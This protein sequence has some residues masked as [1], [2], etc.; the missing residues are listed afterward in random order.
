MR[1]ALKALAFRAT[2]AGAAL[3]L[4]ALRLGD[5]PAWR[6]PS[7]VAQVPKASEME[8]FDAA[9]ELGTVEAWDAFLSNYPTG[10]HAD[11]ARAYVK[12]LAEPSAAPAAAVPQPAPPVTVSATRALEVGCAEQSR[13][14]SENSNER[15]KIRF[16]NNSGTTLV[17]QWIDFS[18][19][20]KEYGVLQ[21]GAEMTQETFTTH[22]WIAAYQEGSCR[23]MFLPAAGIS[24]AELL[25]EGRLQRTPAPTAVAKRKPSRHKDEARDHGPTPEQS[26]RNAGMDY[27][28]RACVARKK[29]K[30]VS[31]A[32]IERRAARACVDMGMI[33]LNGKCAPRLK[34]ERKSGEQNKNKPCPK[35]T[36]RNPYGK[37]QPNQ[38]GG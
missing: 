27:D 30:P 33:Y 18:G 11:L 7:A 4:P 10:F 31:Q 20:L 9:K 35:G 17:I 36:Y 34:V 12:K 24:T 15:A 16:V 38:T 8:A 29:V 3:L 2:L 37:C 25:P 1:P 22:P 26:C 23:Q 6:H 14:R 13:L 28:G 21:A 5:T 19:R 32:T